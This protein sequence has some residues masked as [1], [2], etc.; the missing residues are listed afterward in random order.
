MQEIMCESTAETLIQ[1]RLKLEIA[2]TRR[3]PYIFR[4][5]G[6]DGIQL[7]TISGRYILH[8]RNVFQSP[9]YL[10]RG[11]SGIQQLLQFITLIH[12]FQRKQMF[13]FDN[14]F[15]VRVYQTKR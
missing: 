11:S 7:L 15:P 3:S 5:T 4:T 2:R 12:I 10:E 6:K 13:V 14:H 1:L 8:V 9:F